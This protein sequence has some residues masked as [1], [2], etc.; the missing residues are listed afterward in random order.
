MLKNFCDTMT[1][2]VFPVTGVVKGL[3]ALVTIG[4]YI[5]YLK[6]FFYILQICSGNL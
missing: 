6:I 3:V 2:I 4:V 5:Y 1:L